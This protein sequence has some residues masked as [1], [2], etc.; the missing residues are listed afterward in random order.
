MYGNVYD[1]QATNAYWGFAFGESNNL[2]YA[3]AS[4]TTLIFVSYPAIYLTRR[5]RQR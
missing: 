3:L 4:L 5:D 1:L 2:R